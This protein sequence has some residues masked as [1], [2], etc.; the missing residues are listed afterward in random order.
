M[1]ILVRQESVVID[2]TQSLTHTSHIENF[3]QRMQFVYL[4]LEESTD[5]Y[6]EWE[7]FVHVDA[8]Q[9]TKA[10]GEIVEYLG[11]SSMIHINPN[12]YDKQILATEEY[13]E[14]YDVRYLSYVDD[15]TQDAADFL[16]GREVM[17]TGVKN[18]II[19]NQGQSA[20]KIINSLILK[21]LYKP[22]TGV[23]LGSLG[24]TDAYEDGLLIYV[25]SG[26][27]SAQDF[28]HYQALAFTKMVKIISNLDPI[29]FHEDL[30][31]KLEKMTQHHHPKAEYSLINIQN[32]Q[33][34][35]VG[36]ISNENLTVFEAIVFP[37]NT[38]EIPNGYKSSVT[39][40]MAIG[41]TNPG[42]FN[43]FYYPALKAGALAGLVMIKSKNLMGNFDLQVT[44]TDCGAELFYKPYSKPCF[45]AVKDQLGVVHMTT[46]FPS[47]CYG[48]ITTFRE[49][50]IS[51]PIISEFC[52]ERVFSNKPQF[53]EFMRVM[54]NYGFNIR[55]LLNLANIFG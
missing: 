45:E 50:N 16:V 30:R 31:D 28:L 18:F 29:D 51:A 11:W 48:T 54:K 53:P 55:V 27:E 49:L 41:T 46:G 47:V 43:S 14:N 38:T 19:Q 2:V 1:E 33:R 26:L 3:A 36:E 4:N 34:I 23:I 24:I 12:N 22:G 37:G 35:Q 25:E 15:E 20:Q 8:H 52:A 7:F 40:S 9:S 13:F 44:K 5:I 32:G 17:P 42:Y 21:K 10:L 39:I 6:S